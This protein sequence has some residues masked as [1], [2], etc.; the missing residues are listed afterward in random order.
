MTAGPET[1]V[2]TD[3]EKILYGI[4]E[5]YRKIQEISARQD[6]HAEA[7][8][9]LG[10]NMQWLVDNVQ[11]IFQMFASPQF[12]STMTNTLMGGMSNASDGP[13]AGPE[14]PGVPERAD[15]GGS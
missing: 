13:S 6:T 3:P 14:T 4:D 10:Q 8:N 15:T 5:I 2:M 1:P 12:M 7:V 9:S 11:G